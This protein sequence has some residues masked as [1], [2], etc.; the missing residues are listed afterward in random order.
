MDTKDLKSGWDDLMA[1]L[2]R[3]REELAL[4]MHLGRKD[5]AAEWE[6]LEAQFRELK[7]VKGP[8]LKEAVSD[9]SSR[10][11]DELKRGYANIRKLL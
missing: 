3:E 9:A 5:L 6:R 4:K 11:A 7:R 8:A 2:E 10:I 1:K